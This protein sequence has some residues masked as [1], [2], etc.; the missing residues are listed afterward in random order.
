[1]AKKSPIDILFDGDEATKAT[2]HFGWDQRKQ[3][4]VEEAQ[5]MND[6]TNKD[7]EDED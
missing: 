5:S 2:K 6:Q 7:Q 3:Y 4:T 1:M